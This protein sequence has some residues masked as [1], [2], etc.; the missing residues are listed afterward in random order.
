MNWREITDAFR[1]KCI[2]TRDFFGTPFRAHTTDAACVTPDYAAHDAAS[3]LACSCP[4]EAIGDCHSE[5]VR[6]PGVASKTI[7]VLRLSFSHSHICVIGSG[8]EP[9]LLH[10]H[11]LDHLV[12]RVSNACKAMRFLGMLGRRRH[13]LHIIWTT[14]RRR[15]LEKSAQIRYESRTFLDCTLLPFPNKNTVSFSEASRTCN[16]SLS[17]IRTKRVISELRKISVEAFD[18]L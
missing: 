11:D 17:Y 2:C 7:W 15:R 5:A 8:S 14:S 13:F 3:E 16:S 1:V 6:L 10:S 4:I 9:G 18:S 12:R